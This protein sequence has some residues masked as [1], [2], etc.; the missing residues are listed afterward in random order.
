MPHSGTNWNRRSPSV[1]YV[2][3]GVRQIEH[4]PLQPFLGRIQT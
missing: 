3:P 4:S 2:G 1:S